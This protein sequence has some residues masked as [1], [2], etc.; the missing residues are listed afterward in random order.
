MITPP[1]LKNGDT[2]GIVAPARKVS[3]AEMQ[4]AIDILKGWGLNV[5][6][7]KNIFKE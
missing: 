6:L 1:Y 3:F 7:G 5:L 2:I 4:P